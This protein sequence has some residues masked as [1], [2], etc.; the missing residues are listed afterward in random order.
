MDKIKIH[1]RPELVSRI[2]RLSRDGHHFHHLSFWGRTVVESRL[3]SVCDL[4]L[5]MQRKGTES[6]YHEVRAAAEDALSSRLAYTWSQRVG[7][8]C[9][10]QLKKVREGSDST[11]LG[12][13]FSEDDDE[14]TAKPSHLRI[15]S[16]TEV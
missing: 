6:E 1:L 12:L 14:E 8:S 4:V 16:S 9:I 5:G 7:H 2:K 10:D 13:D 15:L 11:A 3:A